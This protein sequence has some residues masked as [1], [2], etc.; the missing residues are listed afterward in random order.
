MIGAKRQRELMEEELYHSPQGAPC[1]DNS[2]EEFNHD[3]PQ[4]RQKTSNSPFTFSTT[5]KHKEVP[6]NG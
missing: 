5:I 3:Y 6:G 4:K 2:N 1:G